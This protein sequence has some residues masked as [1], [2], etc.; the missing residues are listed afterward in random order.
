MKFVLK[1]LKVGRYAGQW[2]FAIVAANNEKIDPRQLYNEREGAERAIE[3]I[4][5]MR[6]APVEVIE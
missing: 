1:Q 3:L 5:S 2:R 6:D 4:R